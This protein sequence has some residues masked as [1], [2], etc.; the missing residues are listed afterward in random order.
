MIDGFIYVTWDLQ[1]GK[2]ACKLKSTKEKKN[3]GKFSCL[4]KNND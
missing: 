3:G 2:Q 4:G 1:I